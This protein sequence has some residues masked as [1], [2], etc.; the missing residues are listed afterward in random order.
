M[1]WRLFMIT[2]I[3]A[4]Q[5]PFTACNSCMEA[6]EMYPYKEL[7]FKNPF[8]PGTDA[9]EAL[10][11]Q[12]IWGRSDLVFLAWGERLVFNKVGQPKDVT[13]YETITSKETGQV[14]SGRY[15]MQA[16]MNYESMGA[17]FNAEYFVTIKNIRIAE[18]MPPLKAP[19]GWRGILPGEHVSRSI[20]N[21]DKV[22]DKYL[23]ELPANKTAHFAIDTS[24]PSFR[25]IIPSISS[26]PRMGPH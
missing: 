24:L 6:C 22:N 26:L 14:W 11:G 5:L 21:N 3:L 7:T 23:I 19:P 13:A 12:K 1:Y 20:A 17:A 16:V 18:R 25:K 15:T 9:A 2:L 8:G 4:L 10:C